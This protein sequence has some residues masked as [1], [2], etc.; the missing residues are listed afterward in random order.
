MTELAKKLKDYRKEKKLTQPELAKELDVAKSVISDIESSRRGASK[1]TLSRLAE[2]SG[3]T[4]DWWMNGTEAN[5]NINEK[6]QLSTT[7]MIVDKLIKE[8]LIKDSNIDDD[9]ARI[10]LNSLKVDIELEL[11]KKGMV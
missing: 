5:N 3:K 7:K 8:G 1:R 4:I 9:V 10:L 6:E 2:H 11:K